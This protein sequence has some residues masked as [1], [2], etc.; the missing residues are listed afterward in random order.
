MPFGLG[1]SFHLQFFFSFFLNSLL[2]FQSAQLLK[3]LIRISKRQYTLALKEKKRKD[4]KTMQQARDC[5]K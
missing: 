3:N 5:A 4:N 1:R 2:P